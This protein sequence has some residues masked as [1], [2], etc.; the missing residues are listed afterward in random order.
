MK[1]EDSSVHPGSSSDT[2][3]LR[4]ATA[5]MAHTPGPWTP[6]LGRD[7]NIRGIR[8]NHGPE[9]VNVVNW[10]GIS[11]AS[12]GNGQ[13]NAKLILAAPDLY[14]ALQTIVREDPNGYYA[15][16]ASKALAG[17]EK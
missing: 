3:R 10:N 11:R 17:V 9:S 5:L 14:A 1:T 7:I 2:M 15:A 13:A 8:G 6:M 4:S 12:S 16:I